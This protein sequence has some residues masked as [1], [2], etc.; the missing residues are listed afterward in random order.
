VSAPQQPYG[1]PA[2]PYLPPQDP[3]YA[4]YIQPPAP[5]QPRALGVTAL[6]LALVAVVGA[7]TVL[8]VALVAIGAGVGPRLQGFT[9][10]GGLAL[11]SPVRDWVL[12]AEIAAWSGAVLGLWA[13][14]QGIVATARRRGRGAGIAA[15][16]IAAAGPLVAGA[17]ALLAVLAGIASAAGA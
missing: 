2:A 8:A 10:D 7:S 4:A 15:I 14:V 6:V 12:V 16:V 5:P 9:P 3:R 13:L 17:A 1:A 11:L